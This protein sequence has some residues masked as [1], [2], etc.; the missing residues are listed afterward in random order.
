[1]CL[2]ASFSGGQCSL[3]FC[4]HLLTLRLFD[5]RSFRKRSCLL[6]GCKV[7]MTRGKNYSLESS[8][9]VFL[10]LRLYVSLHPNFDTREAAVTRVYFLCPWNLQFFLPFL[11]VPLLPGAYPLDKALGFLGRGGAVLHDPSRNYGISSFFPCHWLI[12]IPICCGYVVFGSRQHFGPF[13]SCIIHLCCDP[14]K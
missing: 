11:A 10:N 3:V 7:I 2:M 6:D 9:D 8:L 4:R 12:L 1:M 13:R 14:N 5:R